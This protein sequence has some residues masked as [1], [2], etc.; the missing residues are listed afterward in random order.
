MPKKILFIIVINILLLIFGCSS[1]NDEI[2]YDYSLLDKNPMS[3]TY[4][5]NIGPDFFK[6]P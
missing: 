2:I 1:S 5:E 4:G 6:N 3:E